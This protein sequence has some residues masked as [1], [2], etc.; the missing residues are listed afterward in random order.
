MGHRTPSNTRAESHTN[1][2]Q[3][4]PLPHKLPEPWVPPC[5]VFG[6]W[7]SPEEFWGIWTGDTVSFPMGLQTAS[8]TSVPSPTPP[9]GTSAHSNA[10][11][12]ASTTLCQALAV[13]QETA[14]SGSCQQA[15][16]GICNNIQVWQMYMGWIPRWGSLWMALPSVYPSHFVS[17]FLPVSIL[18]P[19]LRSTEASTFW[20]S[21]FL[22]FIWSV[23]C[24]LGIPNFW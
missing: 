12:L 16:P 19:V 17:I 9:R 14:M 7:S 10:W 18:F 5:L 22:P 23:N 6:W 24:I 21:F 15:L 11:L 1:V 20:S 4:H 8:A 2:Q 3:G 13:S